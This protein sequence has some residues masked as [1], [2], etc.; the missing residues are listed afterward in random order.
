[1]NRLRIKVGNSRRGLRPTVT[2]PAPSAPLLVQDAVTGF[3]N[4]LWSGT[5]PQHW[6]EWKCCDYLPNW[7]KQGEIAPIALPV[8]KSTVLAGNE[9]WW[10]VKF[11]GVDGTG[12][13]V[14][15]YTNVVSSPFDTA[16]IHNLLSTLKAMSDAHQASSDSQQTSIGALQSQGSAQQALIDGQQTQMG[17]MNGAIADLQDAVAALQGRCP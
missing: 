12:N 14:T 5:P 16:E 4:I 13:P 9:A 2:P 1:M 10:E 3:W 6:Q 8:P 11:V 7:T 17:N 15:P